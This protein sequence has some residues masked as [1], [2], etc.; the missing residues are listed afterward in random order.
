MEISNQDT[1]YTSISTNTYPHI[2]F[3]YFTFVNNVRIFTKVNREGV[4][5]TDVFM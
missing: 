3:T 1:G 5:F 2:N 4:K